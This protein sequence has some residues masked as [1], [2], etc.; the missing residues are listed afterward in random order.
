[1]PVTPEEP[2]LAGDFHESTEFEGLA[3]ARARIAGLEFLDVRFVGCDLTEAELRGCRFESC[4][5]ERCTLSMARPVDSVFHGV[6]FVESKLLGVDF[7]LASSRMPMG[8]RF[9]AC[10]LS[11]ASFVECRLRDAEFRECVLREADLNHADLTG[12]GFPDSDLE[13]ARFGG[14]NLARADFTTAR[15]YFLDPRENRLKET[16]FALPDAVAL[17]RAFDIV[18]E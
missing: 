9:A 14:T 17:L 15:N 11:F 2:R 8:L 3:L 1:M 6:E 7:G 16:R 4:R 18:L 12:G 5:F 10:D 13:G